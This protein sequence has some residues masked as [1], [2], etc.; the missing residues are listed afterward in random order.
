[1]RA[2]WL[3]LAVPLLFLVSCGQTTEPE[4]ADPN[5]MKPIPLAQNCYDPDDPMC[6]PGP[7]PDDPDP[8]APGYFIGLD[9]NMDQ[10]RQ[11]N[12]F[13]A[14]GFD[15]NCEYRIARR[16]A[17]LMAT[18]PSDDVSRE[19]YWVATYVPS[20]PF[21]SSD[22]LKIMYLFSYH[23]DWGDPETGGY[24]SHSGDSEF[25]ILYVE[26]DESTEHWLLTGAFYAAHHEN[27][28]LNLWDTYKPASGFEMPDKV[29]GYPRVWVAND[30]HASYPHKRACNNGGALNADDCNSNVD[31]ER[32]EVSHLRNIGSADNPFTNCVASENPISY[33]GT[34]C[35]WSASY[36]FCGW[37]LDRTNC[38]SPY[39]DHLKEFGFGDVEP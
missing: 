30:K 3:F 34:E 19:P 22:G 26:F 28:A 23:M 2:R 4:S 21:G 33:P 10:C 25:V 37:D 29:N 14:D 39:A 8:D 16:F 32:I 7:S 27:Y 31:D 17:P 13:D 5:F 1:M 18:N 12:D 35:F 24:G 38:S 36:S 20:L 15:D 6:L 11:S 9:Y